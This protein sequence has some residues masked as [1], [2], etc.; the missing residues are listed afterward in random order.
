MSLRI[1]LV[2]DD[3][4]I[5]QLFA[6][7]LDN[8]VFDSTVVEAVSGNHAQEILQQQKFDLIISDYNMQNGNGGDLYR[9]IQSFPQKTPFV[10][11]TSENLEDLILHQNFSR[12]NPLN[13]YLQ[14]PISCE[15]LAHH[16]NQLAMKIKPQDSSLID[17]FKRIRTVFFL[18]FNKTLCDVYLKLSDNKVVKIIA[19]DDLFTAYDIR[20]IVE[21]EIPFLYIRNQDF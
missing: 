11:L 17:E 5:R 20:K 6:L 7:T 18:R 8:F 16:I 9:Y 10:L 13:T 3:D 15:E 14:K 12:D 21:K 4:D 1:L 19:K 2:E